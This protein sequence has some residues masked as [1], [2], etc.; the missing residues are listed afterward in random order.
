ILK[1]HAWSKRQG[2]I[3]E[4]ICNSLYARGSK[5]IAAAGNN[6]KKN[7]SR[8]QACYPAAFDSVLGVGALP[9]S[10]KLGTGTGKYHGTSY[11]NRSD[12]PERTGITTLGGDV[13]LQGN[14]GPQ[15]GILGI[16]L[17]EF[18][19]SGSHPDPSQSSNGWGWWAG[20]SL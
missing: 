20:T 13:D 5:V 17:E 15:E 2:Q 14:V 16:Y 1:N 6:G 19:K 3:I 10:E 11:S 7:Q 9:K 8:P 18:P 12:R 4:R